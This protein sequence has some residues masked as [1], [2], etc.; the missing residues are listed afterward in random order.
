MDGYK[1]T[2]PI[3]YI[4]DRFH[5]AAMLHTVINGGFEGRLDHGWYAEPRAG[6]PA[7][8]KA[9]IDDHAQ[10]IIHRMKRDAY[11]HLFKRYYS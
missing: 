7:P 9:S 1:N 4:I 2:L 6:L 5:F 8:E 10:L 11:N 3:Y